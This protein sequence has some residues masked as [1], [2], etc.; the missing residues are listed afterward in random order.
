MS[1]L[2]GI[3]QKKDRIID[4][5]WK[6]SGRIV[7]VPEN[8]TTLS[9]VVVKWENG[10]KSNIWAASIMLDPAF[11]KEE[12]KRM[13]S[14]IFIPKVGQRVKIKSIGIKGTVTFINQND[15]FFDHMSPIQVEL[16]RAY[17]DS[18]HRMYRAGLQDL[19]K[20][21]KKAPVP[22][23]EDEEAVLWD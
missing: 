18:G 4:R 21:K 1:R 2:P 11:V 14:T 22:I 3:Y 7:S 6:Q 13:D 15:L 8:P 12:L 5:A 20:L 17:D 19:K 23:V 16:D 9:S 10:R